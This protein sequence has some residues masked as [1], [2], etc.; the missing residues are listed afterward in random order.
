M[1]KSVK[2]ALGALACIATF[3]SFITQADAAKRPRPARVACVVDIVYTF[4]AQDGTVLQTE[5]YSNEF[6]LVEGTSFVDDRSTV[7]RE[8]LFVASATTVGGDVVISIDWFADTSVFNS[9]DLQTEMTIAKGQSAGQ[10]SGRSRF[11]STPGHATVTYS[12]VGT[13]L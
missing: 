8:K 13:K 9:S 2:F 11:S 7:T 12:V 3:A 6:E 5:A 4:A 1:S 10:T